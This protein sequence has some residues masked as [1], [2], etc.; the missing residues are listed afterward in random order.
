MAEETT[1]TQHSV[2][3]RVHA[4]AEFQDLRKR[5]RGFAIPAT[6]AFMA[7]YLLYVLMSNWAGGFMGTKV[8]GNINVALVFGLLQFVT[9]FAHRLGSTRR[10]A[11]PKLD[12]LARGARERDVPPRGERSTMNEHQTLTAILFLAVVAADRRHHLLGQPADDGHHRLLR[13]RTLVQRL[14]ERPRDLRRLHVG[15]VVPRH[16]RRHRAVRLRRVPV[17][18][19]LPGRLAR[20]AAAGRRAAAQLRPLHD[21]RPAGLPDAA[22]AGPD[23]G[24]D[25]DRRGVDLLPAR[26]DGRRGRA[27]RAAARRR[28]ASGEEPHDRRASAR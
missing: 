28:A 15:G 6:I 11:D 2:Y 1:P 8:V 17:L 26:P 27:R 5:Y 9:T 12:P 16:L 23:G 24:G 18:D 10:H 4:S 22:A 21:G 25:L 20:G 14:P 19:R 13:R 3:E 7:W